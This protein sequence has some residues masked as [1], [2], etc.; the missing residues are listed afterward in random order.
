[1]YP[2]K[3]GTTSY[4]YPD[5]I[6]PN[7][8]M[9]APYLD[10]IEL[11]LFEST[12]PD[13]LPSADEVNKLSRIAK[14]Q[15]LTYNVHLPFDLSLG[16]RDSNH[17]NNWVK[18]MKQIIGLTAPLIPSTYTLHLDFPEASTAKGNMQT[19]QEIAYGQVARLISTGIEAPFLSIETLGY[20]FEWIEDIIIALNLS[21]CLDFGHL[22]AKKIDYGALFRRHFKRTAIIHLHGVEAGRDHLSLDRLPRKD[23]VPIMGILKEYRKVVSIEV[24]SFENLSRSLAFLEK[25]F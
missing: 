4:I 17:E 21:V 22:I 8:K 13:N 7:V 23:I 9:L 14:D 1:M 18:T 5:H 10:E 11:I 20:P 6:Y 19:W 15:D 2:F 16:K 3:L 25:Y 12:P 24:F